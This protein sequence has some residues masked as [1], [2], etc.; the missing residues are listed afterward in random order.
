MTVSEQGKHEDPGK[1]WQVG[2]AGTAA[3]CPL[4]VHH[5]EDCISVVGGQFH[6]ADHSFT[7]RPTLLLQTEAER[8]KSG[9]QE[10]GARG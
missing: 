3:G 7:A 9:Q 5:G 8:G 6:I 10:K 4:G 1:H 2:C